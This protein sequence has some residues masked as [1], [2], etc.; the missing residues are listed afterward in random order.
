MKK[1]F[2]L[3]VAVTML[4]ACNQNKPDSP[5]EQKKTEFAKAHV[6]EVLG[7]NTVPS[8][9]YTQDSVR[10]VALLTDTSATI[11]LYGVG[12]SERMPVTIDM[13]IEGIDYSRHGATSITLAGDSIAPTMGGRPFDRYMITGLKGYITADSLVFTNNYGSYENCKF[14]G[15]VVK[16]EEKAL[17]TNDAK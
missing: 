10:A 16:M 11:E 17:N 13:N 6:F 7:T 8:E 1:F 15:K 3:A 14:A 4:A 5:E 12:F 9:N 2:Y